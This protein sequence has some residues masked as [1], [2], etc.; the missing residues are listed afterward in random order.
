MLASLRPNEQNEIGRLQSASQT[1]LWAE[2]WRHLWRTG[3]MPSLV[4]PPPPQQF[5]RNG[6]PHNLV[7]RLPWA[8]RLLQ[9]PQS[10]LPRRASCRR[11]TKSMQLELSNCIAGYPGV[12]QGEVVGSARKVP[13][14]AT[15]NQA[16]DGYCLDTVWILMFR[17]SK[18]F[19]VS[20]VFLV[21]WKY[22]MSKHSDHSVYFKTC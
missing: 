15:T 18:Y 3:A 16:M 5:R 19:K 2:E 9:P 13:W 20:I 8:W 10:R 1:G 14:G 7:P 21:F 12:A 6:L 4:T 11:L 17:S 22:T